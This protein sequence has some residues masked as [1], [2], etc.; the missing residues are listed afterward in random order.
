MSKSETNP[1][2]EIAFFGFTFSYFGFVSDFEIR[3]SNLSDSDF[4]IRT[5]LLGYGFCQKFSPLRSRPGRVSTVQSPS[6]EHWQERRIS[7]S[8]PMA[9]SMRNM[10]NFSITPFLLKFSIP[11][12][13]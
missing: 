1:N 9:D 10:V 2:K 4:E 5:Y 3:I 13:T 11:F 6:T 12:F 8:K 7:C